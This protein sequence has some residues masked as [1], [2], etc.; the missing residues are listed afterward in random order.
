MK[1]QQVKVLQT[2]KGGGIRAFPFTLLGIV[3]FW[4]LNLIGCKSTSIV[5]TE[6]NDEL[7]GSIGGEARIFDTLNR[8]ES[9]GT[10]VLVTL[11]DSLSVKTNSV[12]YWQFD[13]VPQGPH[14]L[15]EYKSFCDTVI[16]YNISVAG[17]G[18]QYYN[19][20]PLHEIPQTAFVIER[21]VDSTIHSKYLFVIL[22]G[23]GTDTSSNVSVTVR[24]GKNFSDLDTTSALFFP[25]QAALWQKGLREFAFDSQDLNILGLRSGDYYYMAVSKE[26]YGG[27]FILPSNIWVPTKPGAWSNIYKVAIP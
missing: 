1:Y 9:S 12:G 27:Y 22:G 26:S 17:P 23:I 19:L 13:N 10:D 8:P 5:T 15:R 3:A 21:A 7:K 6:K 24:F 14:V 25:R 16:N 2:K 18:L 11:D 4:G 20:I